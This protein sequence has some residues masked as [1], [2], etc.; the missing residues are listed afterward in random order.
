MLRPQESQN[1]PAAPSAPC[2]TAGESPDNGI[3]EFAPRVFLRVVAFI[4]VCIGHCLLACL[5]FVCLDKSP[6]EAGDDPSSLGVKWLPRNLVSA[7][8][9]LVP[10]A[11]CQARGAS[12]ASAGL[13]HEMCSS[14]TRKAKRGAGGWQDSTNLLSCPRGRPSVRHRDIQSENT[15]EGRGTGHH[16]LLTASN[17]A[18]SVRDGEVEPGVLVDLC[19][20]TKG[21]E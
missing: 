3:L 2:D 7:G 1:H 10:P 20:S 12:W 14:G 17:T 11:S 16:V 4:C 13:A 19:E 18:S 21:R 5:L 6:L 15:Q 9:S 8:S